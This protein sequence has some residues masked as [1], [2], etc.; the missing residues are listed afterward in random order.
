MPLMFTHPICL[1][2]SRLLRLFTGI[3]LSL[4]SENEEKSF[5]VE[6][7]AWSAVLRTEEF[8]IAL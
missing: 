7:G 5:Y 8:L 6:V 3:I 4:N 2:L 1:A